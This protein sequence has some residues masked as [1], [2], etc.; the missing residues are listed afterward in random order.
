MSTTQPRSVRRLSRRLEGVH[1]TAW[2]INT[3]Q[4]D[5][6]SSYVSGLLAVERTSMMRLL[7]L[8]VP[9]TLIM[10]LLSPPDARELYAREGV[11][12][13]WVALQELSAID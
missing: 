3:G 4:A 10:D 13:D 2:R 9:L 8:R 1:Y 6:E 7:E 5:T 11:S 12:P